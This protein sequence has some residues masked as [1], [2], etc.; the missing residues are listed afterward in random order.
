M[1]KE[2]LIKEIELELNEPIQNVSYNG[3]F[4]T[5]NKIVLL[6]PKLKYLLSGQY[7]SM[8]ISNA[9]LLKFILTEG[10]L[11]G[12]PNRNNLTEFN[13]ESLDAREGVRIIETYIETFFSKKKEVEQ[14]N[15]I[16]QGPNIEQDLKNSST[17]F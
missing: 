10:L 7:E 14:V 1:T 5:I 9:V 17:A 11:L 13:L 6:A 3:S 8:L 2:K 16:N 4:I 15:Q 12:L